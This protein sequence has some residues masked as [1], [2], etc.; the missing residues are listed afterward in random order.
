[1][2]VQDALF[3]THNRLFMTLI[4]G[5][6]TPLLCHPL[7]TISTTPPLSPPQTT[8]PPPCITLSKAI[9]GMPRIQRQ[10][11]QY[12]HRPLKPDEQSLILDQRP[13]P[14]FPQLRNAIYRPYEDT[15]RR[16]RQR[17]QK[18]SKSPSTS[19]RTMRRVQRRI[20]IHT[21]HPPHGPNS[22]IRTQRL[23]HRQRKHLE[24]QPCH[25]DVIA[26]IRALIRMAGR[27][28]HAAAHGLQDEGD[29]VAGDEDA[30][31]EM[32][33]EAGVCGAEG[34]D[35]VAEGEVDA[36]G[37]EGGGDRKG[38]DLE[39]ETGLIEIC[40]NL[41]FFEPCV[42]AVGKLRYT[43]LIEWIP[44]THDPAYITQYL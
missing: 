21:L 39:Q 9:S 44:P 42:G 40:K 32:G 23:K 14:T 30:G 12:N 11:R 10:H 16:Q 17:Y 7:I 36:C 38:D 2:I 34:A 13:L 3:R 41:F 4:F 1:M 15:H 8:P 35:E 27:A 33:C 29:D 24:C 26:H 22:K 43:Y 25:H 37:E 18:P 20:T 28:R 5:H 6:R 19:Q 31:I